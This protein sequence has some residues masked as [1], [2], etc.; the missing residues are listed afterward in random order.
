MLLRAVFPVHRCR[1]RLRHRGC[2][3]RCCWRRSS[4][5]SAPSSDRCSA[6]MADRH[7]EAHGW[8]D[9]LVPALRRPRSRHLRLRADAVIA[10]RAAR[11]RRSDRAAVVGAQAMPERCSVENISKRFGG[12][13]AVDKASFTV[14]AGQHHGADRAERRGQDHAVRRSSR[15]SSRPEPGRIV[16]DGSDITG[17]PPHRICAAR[18]RAHLPDRAA[19]RRAHRAREHRGR[20]LSAPRADRRMRWPRRTRSRA[21]WAWPTQLDQPAPT[22]PSPA[23]SAWNWPARWPSGRGCC[24]STR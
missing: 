10:V 12:L 22:S 14:D 23:A 15:A 11:H 9:Q 5:A 24:C 8:A 4:A 20:R 2:R 19:V 7:Q 18:H 17:L 3:S 16:F 6:R 1:H 21:P 13:L